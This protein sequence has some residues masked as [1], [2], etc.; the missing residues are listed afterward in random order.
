MKR[1]K[2]ATLVMLCILTVGLCGIFAYGISGH[3]IYVRGYDSEAHESY[4]S[5]QL[6]MEK[7]VPLDGIDKISILYDMNSNDVYIYESEGD[8]LIIKEYSELDLKEKDLSTVTVTGSGIEVRGKMR[9]G[10]SYQV[11]IGMFG[12]RSAYCYTEIGLPSSYKGQLTFATAS[13]D[14]KSQMNIALEKEFKAATSSGDIIIPNI[15][16][17]NVS[18]SCS[19]GDVEVDVIN[20]EVNNATGAIDLT[21]SS[22]DIDVD[23]LTGEMNIEST[24]G[25]ITVKQ[26]TGGTRIKSSSGNIESEV[27]SGNTQIETTSGDIRVKHIDGAVTAQASSGRVEIQEGSGERT[28]RTTSGDIQLKGVDSAWEV[29]S[30][31]GQ[32][33]IKARE[34]SGSVNTTSGD[35]ELEL[36]KLTGNLRFDCSSGLVKIKISADNAFDFKADT[37]SGDIQTF[38]DNDLNFSKRGNSANGTYGDNKSGSRFEVST[39]SG[40]V[41]VTD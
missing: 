13:G 35:I 23:Q 6:V 21:T 32:V 20:T 2:I 41:R 34:G 12:V 24:S 19:S 33:W 18:L 31:S 17:K 16:A 22:G 26:L 4:G 38:F 1:V 10:K 29:R 5:P 8:V 37:T 36:E 14:I 7:E 9:N 28:V 15:T 27:I 30:S 25:E 11:Q 39:T 3:D 40:D